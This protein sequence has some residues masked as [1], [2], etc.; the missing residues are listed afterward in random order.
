MSFFYQILT[1]ASQISS[2]LQ[3]PQARQQL[4]KESQE[5]AVLAKGLLDQFLTGYVDGKNSELKQF[6]ESYQSQQPVASASERSASSNKSDLHRPE[7][8]Q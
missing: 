7:H 3:D 5:Y 1:A 4:M 2:S 8:L 6:M